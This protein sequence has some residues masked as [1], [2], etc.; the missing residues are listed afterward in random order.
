LEKKSLGSFRK[1]LRLIVGEYKRDQLN[2]RAKVRKSS[3]A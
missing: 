2:G 3:A 1:G